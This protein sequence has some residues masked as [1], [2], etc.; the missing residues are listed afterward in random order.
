M[1]FFD[2]ICGRK[3]FQCMYIHHRIEIKP[4]KKQK[5]FFRKSFGIAR[6][7]YNWGIDT[8]EQ[9]TNEGKHRSAFELTKIFNSIKADQFP[10]VLKVSK[11]VP[12]FAFKHLQRAYLNY[13]KSIEKGDGKYGKPTKK[14]KRD[15]FGSYTFSGKEWLLSWTNKNSKELTNQPHNLEHK[16]QYLRISKDCTYV[17]M[18]EPLRFNGKISSVTIKQHSDKFYAIFCVNITEEEYQRTHKSANGEGSLGID[19][20][21]HSLMAL[22]NGLLVKNPN[23]LEKLEKHIVHLQRK[24]ERCVHPHSK[25]QHKNGVQKSKNYIKACARYSKLLRHSWSIRDDFDQKLTTCLVRHYSDIALETLDVQ[26]MSKGNIGKNKRKGNKLNRDAAWYTLK[27][28]IINKAK[29]MGRKTVQVPPFTK[30]SSV[31]SFCG[32]E[33]EG[34]T[35]RNRIL[36]CPNCGQSIERDYNAALNIEKHLG[37]GSSEAERSKL[38][39][40]AALLSDFKKNRIVT[41]Q[42]EPGRKYTRKSDKS[43]VPALLV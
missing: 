37:M 17:K 15:R 40:C 10:F 25:R 18:M 1:T 7:A 42:V 20:G 13:F 30:T 43:S 21:V 33:V 8:W 34:V 3:L 27:T 2:Y 14:K 28:L 26:P 36:H 11:N 31:C 4:N 9:L 16:H 38:A 35:V 6:F 22:S 12:E 29:R 19:L 5:T 24:S 39:D 23:V 41:T 32:Y